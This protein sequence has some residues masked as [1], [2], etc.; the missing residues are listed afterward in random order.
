MT[1]VLEIHVF[2]DA[3]P[4]QIYSLAPGDAL[5]VESASDEVAYPAL[6]IE[7]RKRHS[8]R[9]QIRSLAYNEELTRVLKGEQ[10]GTP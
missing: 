2:F 8:L 6:E 1:K 3:E 9:L 10:R 4:E 5:V 7:Y